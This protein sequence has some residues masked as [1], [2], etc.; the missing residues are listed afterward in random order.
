MEG[1]FDYEVGYL[2]LDKIGFN[3]KISLCDDI[4]LWGFDFNFIFKELDIVVKD[5]FFEFF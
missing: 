4:D 1:Y 5:V 3:V 2:I